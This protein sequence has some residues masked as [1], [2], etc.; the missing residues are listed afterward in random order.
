MYDIDM[1]VYPWAAIHI[2]RGGDKLHI[3]LILYK[4]V[5][6]LL[7]PREYIYMICERKGLQVESKNRLYSQKY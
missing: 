5:Q 2:L 3:E 1:Q 7:A 6:D 4:I